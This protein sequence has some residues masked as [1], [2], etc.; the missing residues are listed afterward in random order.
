MEEKEEAMEVD[1]D[2]RGREEEF[3]HRDSGG[4]FVPG[5]RSKSAGISKSSE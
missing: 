1:D 3:F 2:A 5:S 4:R